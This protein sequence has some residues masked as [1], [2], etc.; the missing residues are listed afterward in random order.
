M[1]GKNTN[2]TVGMRLP[3]LAVRMRPTV[4]PDPAPGHGMQANGF[5]NRLANAVP[6]CHAVCSRATP[7]EWWDFDPTP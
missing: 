6:L 7:I 1:Y 4:R 5:S 2:E 3:F